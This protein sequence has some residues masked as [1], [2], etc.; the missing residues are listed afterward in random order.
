MKVT[1]QQ[2]TELTLLADGKLYQEAVNFAQ[3]QRAV[4]DDRQ[5]RHQIQ[6]LLTFSRSW[7][8]L[9]RFVDHQRDRTWTGR[10][11]S[12]QAF[13]D[14]LHRYLHQLGAALKDTY[15]FVP[16]DLT[17]RETDQYTEFFA[18]QLAST[19]IQHLAAEMMWQKEVGN[20]EQLR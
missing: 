12:Y 15:H 17:K 14:A 9:T 8:E 3:E 4:I 19:F 20:D 13:Y 18:G 16:D 2:E 10:R 5:F 11:E 6:G 1:P 7:E